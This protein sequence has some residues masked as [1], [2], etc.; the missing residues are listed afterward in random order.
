MQSKELKEIKSWFLT[1]NFGSAV[2]IKNLQAVKT[3][4]YLL[5]TKKVTFLLN[6]YEL[7]N[8]STHDSSRFLQIVKRKKDFKILGFSSGYPI[9]RK[10][11]NSQFARFFSS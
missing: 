10:R 3:E 5:L 8:I 1:F 2:H 11:L 9:F 7:R 6:Q 4:F